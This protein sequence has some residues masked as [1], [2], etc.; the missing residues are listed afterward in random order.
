MNLKNTFLLH[1]TYA[2][3]SKHVFA[4][5]ILKAAL[6]VVVFLPLG[7]IKTDILSPLVNMLV[8]RIYTP[9]T[10]SNIRTT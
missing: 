2:H 3:C 8:N 7:E 5:V 9:I 6:I 1:H 4:I 10:Q